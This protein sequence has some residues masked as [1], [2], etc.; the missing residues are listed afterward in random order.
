[1]QLP[2]CR[3]QQPFTYLP[4][5]RRANSETLDMVKARPRCL[6]KS[7]SRP[8]V[9]QSLLDR[10]ASQPLVGAGLVG[11]AGWLDSRKTHYCTSPA[12]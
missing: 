10:R 1:M 12:Q 7:S 11:M 3:L 8:L 9:M 2:Q 6:G 5:K 4:K